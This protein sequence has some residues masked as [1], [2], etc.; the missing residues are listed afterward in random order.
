MK[1]DTLRFQNPHWDRVENFF[2]DPSLERLK[3]APKILFHPIKNR[4]PLEKDR[5]IVMKG[6]RLLCSRLETRQRTSPRE[7]RT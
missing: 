5:V 1:I 2:H 3:T 4:I 7:K 6:P